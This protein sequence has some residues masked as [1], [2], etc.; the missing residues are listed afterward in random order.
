MPGALRGEEE[1]SNTVEIFYNTD[2]K[3]SEHEICFTPPLDGNYTIQSSLLDQQYSLAVA[4][5]SFILLID[6]YDSYFFRIWNCK[7]ERRNSFNFKP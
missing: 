1:Y 4:E 7:C 6:K 5:G 2:F 3:W